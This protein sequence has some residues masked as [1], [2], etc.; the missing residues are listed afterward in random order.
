MKYDAKIDLHGLT[1]QAAYNDFAGF[2]EECVEAEVKVMLVVTGKSNK[3][4]GTIN[5]E[6]PHWC[7]SPKLNRYIKKVKHAELKHGGNG[8]FYVILK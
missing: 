3:P 2:L 5:Y 8:A 6:F 4:E 1:L 7:E